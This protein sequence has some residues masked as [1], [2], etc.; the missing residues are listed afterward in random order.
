MRLPDYGYRMDVNDPEVNAAYR[1][2]K[3]AHGI[4]LHIPLSDAERLEFE[5]AYISGQIDDHKTE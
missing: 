3:V 2:W 5:L 1:R 4:P